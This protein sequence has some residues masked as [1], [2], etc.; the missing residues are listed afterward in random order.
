M[1]SFAYTVMFN[2][3]AASTAVPKGTAAPISHHNRRDAKKH[4]GGS[5]VLPP[6]FIYFGMIVFTEFA[7][8]FGSGSPFG[9]S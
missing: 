6:R 9:N 2:F 3:C 4:R 7:F 5:I 1:G 8:V